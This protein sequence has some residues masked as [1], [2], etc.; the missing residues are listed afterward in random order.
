ML[1]QSLSPWKPRS[2]RRWIVL[3]ALCMG[4]ALSLVGAVRTTIFGNALDDAAQRGEA[5]FDDAASDDPL[6]DDLAF[7]AD[8][9]PIES[10]EIAN[11]L[12]DG[13]PATV[14]WIG[15]PSSDEIL[16]RENSDGRHT[17]LRF[18]KSRTVRAAKNDLPD[19]QRRFWLANLGAR[20][21]LFSRRSLQILLCC[22]RV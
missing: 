22:W 19:G 4:V 18:A 5:M 8:P 11:P 14:A 15:L 10:V 1:S 7:S 9:E 17:A 2:L 16:R 6:F 12:S 13:I 3:G 21:A 20:I